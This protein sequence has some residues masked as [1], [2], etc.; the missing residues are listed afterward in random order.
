MDAD[1]LRELRDEH[2]VSFKPRHYAEG[3]VSFGAVAMDDGYL[4][5][6]A[7]N[8]TTS[9]FKQRLIGILQQMMYVS[10]ETAE[11][12]AETTYLIEEIVREQVV[13]MVGTGR[14]SRHFRT[15]GNSS[16]KRQHWPTDADQSRF[17]SWI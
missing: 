6:I 13:E 8:E 1:V 7:E 14:R 4:S 5:S 17:L 2:G 10:G 3:D 12:S 16:K 11:P 9:E 15:D